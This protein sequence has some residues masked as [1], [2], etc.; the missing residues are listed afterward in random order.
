MTETLPCPFPYDSRDVAAFAARCCITEGYEHNITKIQKLVYCAYG[1]VLAARGIRLCDESPKAGQYGPVFPGIF[2]IVASG[3]ELPSTRT[4]CGKACQMTCDHLSEELC[5][6][7]ADTM[8][9]HLPTGPAGPTLPGQPSQGRARPHGTGLCVTAISP[10]A[11][12]CTSLRRQTMHSL[13]RSSA[14]PGVL[15]RLLTS[16]GRQGRAQQ[17]ALP[18][19]PWSLTRL[20]A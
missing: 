2:R 1:V 5:T 4:L 11:L 6:S 15:W 18:D 20:L 16:S 19:A 7:L 12:P 14:S 10:A 17:G 3:R 13:Q 9:P 8:P